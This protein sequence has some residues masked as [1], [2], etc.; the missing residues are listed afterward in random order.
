MVTEHLLSFDSKQVKEL[1][2]SDDIVV[3]AEEEVFK[4][5]LNW[6]F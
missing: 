3:D 4:G 2:S 1:M 6:D 5:I